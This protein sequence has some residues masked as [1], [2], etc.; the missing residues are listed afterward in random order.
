MYP[1]ISFLYLDFNYTYFMA[2][3][4][5][6]RKYIS[7]IVVLLTIGVLTFFLL[8]RFLTPP[9]NRIA[10]TVKKLTANT[11]APNVEITV[12]RV[13]G[14]TVTQR[15]HLEA[16]C[17]AI[18]GKDFSNCNGPM[19]AV[20]RDGSIT[21]TGALY[22]NEPFVSPTGSYTIQFSTV[23]TLK[24]KEEPYPGAWKSSLTVINREG[25]TVQTFDSKR[26]GDQF[27]DVTPLT[28]S[29][30]EKYLFL[31]AWAMRGGDFIDQ[32]VIVKQTVQDKAFEVIVRNP[33]PPEAISDPT[34]KNYI[35]SLFLGVS[36]DKKSMFVEE[37]KTGDSYYHPQLLYE[38]DFA[39]GKR[40]RELPL[41]TQGGFSLNFSPNQQYFTQ[42]VDNRVMITK[43][44]DG[45][46]IAV[47]ASIPDRCNLNDVSNDGK[48][49]AVT[50]DQNDKSE[51][52]MYDVRS[53]K[54]KLLTSWP[55]SASGYKLGETY[56]IFA[57]FAS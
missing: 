23:S 51:A 22:S 24:S 30:D 13:D 2:I 12:Q 7:T 31:Q 33:N 52:W 37:M 21:K 20:Q 44:N 35:L 3:Q 38:Y 19:Y 34:V 55:T 28:F 57:G 48:R 56:N 29:Q 26:Y 46:V 45:K 14:N 17:Y 16:Q 5:R 49:I 53:E 40:K 36:V 32:M 10:A 25:K 54:R 18:S 50:C 4:Y 39:T 1:P 8:P 15:A 11:E 47:K 42:Q 9:Y 43:V 41:N 27:I 6:F